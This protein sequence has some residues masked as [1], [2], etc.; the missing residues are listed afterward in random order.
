M[1]LDRQV[2]TKLPF[3]RKCNWYLPFLDL[4]DFVLLKIPLRIHFSP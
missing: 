4:R 1:G 3:F 2:R